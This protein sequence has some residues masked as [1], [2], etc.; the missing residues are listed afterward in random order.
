MLQVKACVLLGGESAAMTLC[1]VLRVLQPGGRAASHPSGPPR[2]RVIGN[3][4]QIPA[5]WSYMQYQFLY[6][7]VQPIHRG[8]STASEMSGPLSPS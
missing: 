8:Y 1:T 7:R 3:A 4:Y 5:D 2:L 6:I